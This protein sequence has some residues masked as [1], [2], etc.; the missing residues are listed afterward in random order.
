MMMG[1]IVRRGTGVRDGQMD[2]MMDDRRVTMWP[3]WK[4]ASEMFV[5]R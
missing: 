2:S 1:R 3:R 5:L 4:M